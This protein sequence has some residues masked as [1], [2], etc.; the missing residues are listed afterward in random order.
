MHDLVAKNL[1]ALL[2]GS[3]DPITERS[4]RDHLVGCD[5]C[6]N[7]VKL[8]QTQSKFLASFRQEE[9]LAPGPGFYAKVRRQIEAQQKPT[10]W[11]MLLD[12]G[13][14]KRLVWATASLTVLMAGFLWFSSP[15]EQQGGATVAGLTPMSAIA[16]PAP[17]EKLVPASAAENPVENRDA[18]FANLASY[19]TSE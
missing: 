7:R 18:V 19:S 14:G 13:F 15:V 17:E 10:L 4:V 9:V 6:R 5:D 12:P 2:D 16:Q 11:D 8:L 3:I 1:E